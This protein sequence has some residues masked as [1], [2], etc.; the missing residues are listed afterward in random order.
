M[1]TKHRQ[2]YVLVQPYVYLLYTS[3]IFGTWYLVR[4]YVR[5]VLEYLEIKRQLSV[6]RNTAASGGLFIFHNDGKTMK[7]FFFWC[8]VLGAP[9]LLISHLTIMS[10]ATPGIPWFIIRAHRYQVYSYSRLTRVCW[11]FFT[12]DVSYHVTG[13]SSACTI[14]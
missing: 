6:R 13:A 2:L 11:H 10:Y 9:P 12:T 8:S 4:W 7:C 1:P 3:S 5:I 14:S